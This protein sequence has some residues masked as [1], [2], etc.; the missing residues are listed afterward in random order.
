MKKYELNIGHTTEFE[1]YS[2]L[3]YYSKGHHDKQEFIEELERTYGYKGDVDKVKHCHCK[4]T[5]S[6]TGGI[7][8]NYKKEPCKGSFPITLL[9]I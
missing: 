9:E 7:M 3:E 5:P 1:G 4:T 8:F 6:P 2:I